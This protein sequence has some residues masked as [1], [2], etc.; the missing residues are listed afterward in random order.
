[1]KRKNWS[2]IQAIFVFE[3]E[4][5]EVSLIEKHFIGILMVSNSENRYVLFDMLKFVKNKEN[6]INSFSLHLG[7]V[8]DEFILQGKYDQVY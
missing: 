6:L 3:L 4:S 5:I 1:M 2:K 7:K 8:L